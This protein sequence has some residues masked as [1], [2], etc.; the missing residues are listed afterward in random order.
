MPSLYRFDTTLSTYNLLVK[1]FSP[2]IQQCSVY[3]NISE[4]VNEKPQPLET[5]KKIFVYQI[6]SI[7]W[8]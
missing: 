4:T 8:K 2:C 7:K 1:G 6:L 5:L 3:K